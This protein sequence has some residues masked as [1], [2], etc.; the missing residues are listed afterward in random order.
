MLKSSYTSHDTYS[1]QILIETRRRCVGT[2]HT[3]YLIVDGGVLNQLF[4]VT[5]YTVNTR[6]VVFTNRPSGQYYVTNSDSLL[7]QQTVR[8]FA[9]V[10]FDV[11][12][13]MRVHDSLRLSQPMVVAHSLLR[14]RLLSYSTRLPIRLGLFFFHLEQKRFMSAWTTPTILY[15]PLHYRTKGSVGKSEWI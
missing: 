4:F 10:E 11:F 13:S 7:G 8:C 6:Y 5:A 12:I 3:P 14:N 2:T 1:M 9:C 15:L